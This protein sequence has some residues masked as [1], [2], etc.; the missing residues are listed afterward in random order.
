PVLNVSGAFISGSSGVGHSQNARNNWELSN[1]TAIQHGTHAIKF[2]GRA[3]GV[4]IDDTNPNNFGG[5]LFFT[6]GF[7]LTSIERYQLTLDLQ[8]QGKTPE[9][10]RAAGGGASQFTIN[11]GDPL[12]GVTQKDYG[13]FIQDDWRVRPNLTL[14][15]GLRYEYQT[16]AASKFN[17]APRVALAWSPGAA[18]S[19]RPPKMVI[20]LGAGIFYNRFSE[21][22][23]LQ[24]NRF[25]G[26][27]QHQ[28]FVSETP[29]FINGQFVPPVP[30]PLD[31]FPNL[32]PITGLS[33]ARQVTWR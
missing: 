30:S 25:D 8:R 27:N 26:E 6:G 15:A 9:E 2:G 28:F 17:F 23:V 29:L 16:N 3:R 13:L 20:R 10:I 18:N 21:N 24:A 22:S 33:V 4:N 32:P 31:A 12:A 19:A 7:G 1:F 5:T 11:T 14:S